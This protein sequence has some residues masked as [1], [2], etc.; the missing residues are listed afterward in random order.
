MQPVDEAGVERRRRRPR[1]EGRRRAVRRGLGRHGL[2][3]GVHGVLAAAPRVEPGGD[4][5]RD[6]VDAARARRRPCRRW[7]RNRA[8]R[9]TTSRSGRRWRGRS[10]ASWRSSMRVVPAWLASPGMSMRHR[11]CGQMSVPMATARAGSERSSVPSGASASALP[12]S[13]CSSTK[14]ADAADGLV[15]AAERRRGRVRPARQA[16]AIVTPSPSA[17][18]RARS[19]SRAPVMMREPAQAMPKRAPSSSTKLTTPSG[20]SG[21]NP[22]SRSASTVARALTTPSGPSKAPPSGTESRCEPMTTPGVVSGSPHQAHWLP[23]RSSTTSRPR[24]AH[25]PANHSRRSW[26]VRVQ[27]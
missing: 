1:L 13:T 15:V 27:A 2:D 16:S 11:P 23:A 22:A 19:A 20:T 8:P 26:S 5:A 10:S 4:V 17:S 21:S 14:R 25:S 12:C 9:H 3:R 24:A 6:R 7:R 18:E